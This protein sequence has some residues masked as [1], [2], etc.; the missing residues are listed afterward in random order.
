MFKFRMWPVLATGFLVLSAGSYAIAQDDDDDDDDD[1]NQRSSVAGRTYCQTL[2]I[3]GF[4]GKPD[5]T[6]EIPN[7]WRVVSSVTR[8]EAEFKAN[9]MFDY[10]TES[11]NLMR[12]TKFGDV[13]WVPLTPVPLSG[14]FTQTDSRLDATFISPVTNLPVTRTLYVSADG[15][16][17]FGTGLDF[18]NFGF[19]LDQ[20]RVLNSSYIEIDPTQVSCQMDTTPQPPA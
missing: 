19:S 15:S 12:L 9:G 16:L 5:A 3:D 6:S 2:V 7:V 17:I 18:V 11:S 14:S 13:D 20:T 8:R 4:T 1:D 10:R